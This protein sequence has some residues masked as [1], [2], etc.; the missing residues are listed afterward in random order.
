[1]ANY[2]NEEI[3]C[4]AY[5]HL[6]I[7]VYNDKQALQKL[8]NEL[9]PFFEERAKF[10]LGDN[11]KVRVEFEEGSLKTKLQVIGSAGLLICSP[12]IKDIYQNPVAYTVGAIISYPTFKESVIHLSQDISSLAQSANLE[13]IFRT[14]AKYCDRV[15]VE[16]RKGIIGRVGELISE[17]ENIENLM[18]P[19]EIRSFDSELSQAENIVNKLIKWE[20]K[21]EILFNKLDNPITEECFASGLNEALKNIP[22]KFK[23]EAQLDNQSLKTKL[24][25]N[26]TKLISDLKAVAIRHRSALQ[27]ISQKLEIRHDFAKQK[28]NAIIEHD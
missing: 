19:D 20:G 16:K 6:E 14:K 27:N 1:M 10:L 13:V 8:E 15:T 18:K 24:A 28:N 7:D 9:I 22:K 2:I 12:V 26:D 4:E 25:H 21:A 11:I 3:L 17:L 23:W 5:T